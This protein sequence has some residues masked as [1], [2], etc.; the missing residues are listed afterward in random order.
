[1]RRNELVAIIQA[2]ADAQ[3]AIS[4]ATRK[5]TQMVQDLDSDSGDT[6]GDD[7]ASVKG[8]GKGTDNSKGQANSS[9]K[10]GGKDGKG[11]ANSSD[12]GGG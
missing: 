8:G 10:G 1:M 5:V 6:D 11:Q 4:W 12:K 3:G 9:D 2:L 7:N